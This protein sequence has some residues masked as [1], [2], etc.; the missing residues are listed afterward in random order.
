MIV[1]GLTGSIGMGKSMAATMLESLRIPVHEADEAVHELLKPG[2]KGALAV[3]KAFPYFTYPQIYGRKTKSGARAINRK[4]LGEIVFADKRKREKLEKI[5]HPL[6]RESQN[7]FIRRHKNAKVIVLDIPLLFE[8]GGEKTVDA[9][10][11]VSAPYNVQRQRVLARP[12]MSEKKFQA[13]LE[14]QLPD[15]EKRARADYIVHTGLG[16]AHMMQELKAVIRDLK[17]S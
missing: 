12:G 3:G 13:I 14:R 6:V 5:L 11:V 1:I 8:T 4:K 17:K 2:A 9:V 15:S 16:R 10:I 7:E